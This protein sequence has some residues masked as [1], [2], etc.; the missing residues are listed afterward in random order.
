M[1]IYIERE[2][3]TE[4]ADLGQLAARSGAFS[5]Y[6]ARKLYYCHVIMISIIISIISIMFMSIMFSLIVL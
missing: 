6:P 2:R 3:G 5:F 4:Q 1:S